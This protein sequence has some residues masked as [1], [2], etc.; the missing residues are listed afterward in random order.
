MKLDEKWRQLVAE[1]HAARKVLD[2][3]LASVFNKLT[4]IGAG[5]SRQNSTP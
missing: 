5:T 1:S 2:E 4:A 3:A